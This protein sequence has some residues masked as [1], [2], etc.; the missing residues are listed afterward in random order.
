[1]ATKKS[2]S[3]STSKQ[4]TTKAQLAA[5]LKITTDSSGKATGFSDSKGSYDT[6]GRAIVSGKSNGPA[7]DREGIAKQAVA[8]TTRLS[9]A[10]AGVPTPGV[11]PPAD[12]PPVVT[13]DPARATYDA[14]KAK[15]DKMADSTGNY[16]DV[17]AS[18]LYQETAGMIKDQRATLKQRKAD[19]IS[20]I[21]G[22]YNQASQAQ[23]QKQKSE[24]GTQS[25]GLARIGGFDSAS[26]QAVLTNLQRVHESE[27]QALMQARQSAILQA[28]QAYEDKDFALAKL[29]MD[30]A[31][32]AEALI[33]NRQ[34]DYIRNTLAIRGEERADAQIEYGKLRDKVSDQRWAMQWANE[35]GITGKFFLVGQTAFDTSTGEAL[36]LA[37]Y[38]ART[39]QQVGLPAEQTDFSMIQ[40]LDDAREAKFVKDAERKAVL[41]MQSKY[42]DAGILVTDSLAQAES[43]LNNSRIYKEQVRPPS[44]GGGMSI[45]QQR[46]LA[47]TATQTLKDSH[48]GG[49]TYNPNTYMDLRND[50][51][52]TGGD[53]SVFDEIHAPGLSP[54]D[55]ASL[56]IGKA[57]GYDVQTSS[58][59]KIN[60][61]TGKPVGQ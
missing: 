30:E 35:N 32:A 21:T 17:Y 15:I 55:K 38:Q 23:V 42:V 14:M 7:L 58:G 44:S 11:T 24:T 54:Q 9:G 49:N 22:E 16:A 61:F 8:T 39:G 47:A 25:M 6:S 34:Q 3:S 56:G 60:P 12:K 18:P 40:R 43:K 28:Q 29:Q 52:A 5:G 41:D 57:G 53:P 46:Q 36:P 27:Q 31:K 4:G 50:F 20:R 59:G 1:M 10:G 33:Y 19:E 51:V 37:E 2:S 48:G 26:G 45:T 13:S